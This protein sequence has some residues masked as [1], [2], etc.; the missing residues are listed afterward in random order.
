MSFTSL[1][2]QR[3][4]MMGSI[5][6][7][8]MKLAEIPASVPFPIIC[9]IVRIRGTVLVAENLLTCNTYRHVSLASPTRAIVDLHLHF[10]TDAVKLTRVPHF[11]HTC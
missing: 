2:A 1:H 9:A 5:G 4:R 11:A 7:Q 6:S 8:V 3:R 10:I